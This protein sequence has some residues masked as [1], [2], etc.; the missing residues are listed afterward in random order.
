ML[1]S[2]VIPVYT[3]KRSKE[4]LTDLFDS[5]KRQTYTNYEVIVADHSEVDEIENFCKDYDLEVL[6]YYNERERGNSSVN[7]NF[8]ISK[9]SGD[10]IK[11]MHM[12]DYFCDDEALQ[13]MVDQIGDKKWGKYAFNH[14]HE[15]APNQPSREWIPSMYDYNIGCPSVIFF[16]R[17]ESDQVLFDEELIFI[18][19]MDMNQRLLE[20]YGV[21]AVIEDVCVTV[22]MHGSQVQNEVDPNLK[23][24]E[25]MHFLTKDDPLTVIA[26]RYGTDKGTKVPNPEIHHGPRL[27]FTP[28][29]Y[30]NFKDM[31]FEEMDLLE[32]GIGSGVSL[33]MWSD[34]F[35]NGYIHAIDVVDHRDKNSERVTT[36]V[37]DQSS[38]EQ[39]GRFCSDMEFDIIIDDGSHVIEHQQVSLAVAFDS[40]AP[41]GLYCI[42][43]LHTSD[44]SVWNGK[45]LYGYNMDCDPQNTTVKV[46]ESFID[47]NEFKS[48]FLTDEEN[49]SLTDNI[50]SIKIYDLPKT[51]WGENK[52]AF[53]KK[54]S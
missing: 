35:V 23:N 20:R 49:Q 51:M 52:L 31:E 36:Y 4:F 17:D 14:N 43:D 47:T 53:I 3:M 21:P 30:E 16:V 45:T 38:R 6:H 27:F 22:R 40:L 34:F 44:M 48:P 28:A 11:I 12:D 19:D 15:G 10:I 24:R 1:I 50:E 5:I 42:E 9:A 46:L 7:M 2:I 54:K 32:I 29:Y 41:G 8:G 25:W 33:P 18:N 39:M 26:N 37:V 13:K